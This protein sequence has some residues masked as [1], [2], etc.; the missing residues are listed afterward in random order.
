MDAAR[1]HIL[2]ER[3]SSL[4]HAE[5]RTAA[6]LHGMPL[7]QLQALHFL[8]L[9][10]RYSN[11]PASL[12]EYLGAT[13]GTVSQ[14]LGALESKGLIEKAVDT[15][16][17]RIVRCTL[18][19]AGRVIVEATFPARLLDN[20]STARAAL[21]AETALVELLRALQ[22]ASGNRGFGVCRTCAHHRV[23]AEGAHCGLTNEPL[24][25]SEITKLCREHAIPAA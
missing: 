19:A 3:V 25:V 6:A 18:T 15:K 8:A 16:D 9:A 13:K 1:L 5:E 17:R 7:A 12:T 23:G 22:R 10:N 24:P 11:T 2:L 4:L 21:E 14:T 20:P